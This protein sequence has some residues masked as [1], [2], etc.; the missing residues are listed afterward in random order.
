M[1]SFPNWAKTLLFILVFALSGLV[2]LI[3]IE[4]LLSGNDLT[5]LN[6]AIESAMIQIRTPLLTNFMIAVTTVGSP[7]ALFFLGC[8]LSLVLLLKKERANAAVLFASMVTAIVSF[9]LLKNIF[10]VSRPGSQFLDFTGWS[11]PSGHA[12]VATAFFFAAAH[13]LFGRLRGIFQKMLLVSFSIF[14]AAMVCLSR[15]YLGAHWTLDVL[16]GIALG[17]MSVSFVVIASSAFVRDSRLRT[18]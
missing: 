17:F 3:I 18:R 11:F 8:F 7:F 15:L 1:D 14:G 12:T 10:Q 2:L 4:G 5:P 9:V 13:S 6:V 16:A